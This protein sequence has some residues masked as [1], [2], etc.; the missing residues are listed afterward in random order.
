MGIRQETEVGDMMIQSCKEKG[1][2]GLNFN[3]LLEFVGFNPFATFFISFYVL[4]VNVG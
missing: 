2:V 4:E 1:G 3:Q